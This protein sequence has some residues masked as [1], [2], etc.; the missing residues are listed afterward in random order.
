VR[1][2][3]CRAIFTKPAIA[4]KGKSLT[5]R[6]WVLLIEEKDLI[7][8]LRD[9]GGGNGLLSSS[10]TIADGIH[11]RYREAIFQDSRLKPNLAD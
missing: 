4:V 8:C 5:N 10:L 1:W 6:I 9:L 7:R 11:R 2:T 3:I